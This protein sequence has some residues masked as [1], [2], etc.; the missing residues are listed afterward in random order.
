VAN[1]LSLN[2]D[3]PATGMSRGGQ[4]DRVIFVR[5][6]HDRQQFHRIAELLRAGAAEPGLLPAE[7]VEDESDVEEGRLLFRSHRARERD[8]RLV[9][10]KKAEAL[11]T[12]GKLDCEVCGFDFAVT[13]GELGQGF[14]EIHHVVP[15]AATGVTKTRLADL[16]V[17][18]ANCH[19]MAHHRRPWASIQEL[20]ILIQ[21]PIS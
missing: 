3:V 19:R 8:R 10:R 16:A 12:R 4:L 13:Y 21:T 17:L 18:C 2:P 14:A 1:F 7:P 20:R 5:Y 9:G 15:L 6:T 11:A